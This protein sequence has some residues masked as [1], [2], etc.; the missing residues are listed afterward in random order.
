MSEFTIYHNPRCS[1]SRAT[2]ALLEENGLIPEVVLY[3]ENPLTGSAIKSLLKKLGMRAADVV[4][5]GEAEYKEAGLTKES[6]ETEIVAAIAAQNPV[7]IHAQHLGRA[8]SKS[9]CHRIGVTHQSTLGGLLDR[10]EHVGRRRIGILVGIQLDE[11]A[12]LRLLTGHIP[13]HGV[14]FRTKVA[15]CK[16]T[17]CLG[18]I[19]V[20]RSKEAHELIVA[21]DI[22][23]V[24]S[25]M[26]QCSLQ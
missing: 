7:A 16:S 1:K 23:C 19:P 6:S 20:F 5:R 13:V 24:F 9:V 3:L 14:N 2:L 26:I 8:I 22:F 21:I 10:A 12:H 4:R 18:A 15:H 11:L 25:P 17:V